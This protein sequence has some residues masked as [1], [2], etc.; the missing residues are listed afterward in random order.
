MSQNYHKSQK[1]EGQA[2]PL[3]FWAAEVK[4]NTPTAAGLSSLVTTNS[5]FSRKP[6]YMQ[7][8]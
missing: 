6:L 4:T 2:S 5:S 1:P 7:G 8:S 3:C